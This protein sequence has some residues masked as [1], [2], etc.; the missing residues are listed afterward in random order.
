MDNRR[1]SASYSSRHRNSQGPL[2]DYQPSSSKNQQ[3]SGYFARAPRAEESPVIP[4]YAP[5][6]TA[7]Q[8]AAPSA[9]NGLSSGGSQRRRDSQEYASRAVRPV[10]LPSAPDAPRPVPSTSNRHQYPNENPGSHPPGSGLASYPARARAAKESMRN[11]AEEPY[12]ALSA[13]TPQSTDPVRRSSQTDKR[14][15][16][17]DRSP[18]QRLEVKLD[19][20]SKEEKRARLEE[21]EMLAEER[22]AAARAARANRAVSADARQS[23]RMSAMDADKKVPMRSNS[24]R[25]TSVPVTAS[26]AAPIDLSPPWDPSAKPIARSTSQRQPAPSS[27]PANQNRVGQSAVNRSVSLRD[28]DVPGRSRPESD[29][30]KPQNVNRNNGM[31]GLGLSGI[32]D[33]D[34]TLDPQKTANVGRQ[35]SR[36]VSIQPEEDT[37]GAGRNRG[38]SNIPAGKQQLH[39][40]MGR[41]FGIAAAQEHMQPDPLPRESVR[42]TREDVPKYEIPPQSAAGQL[43]RDQIGFSAKDPEITA[44]TNLEKS[45]GS[46]SL[47]LSDMLH[48][49]RDPVRRYQAPKLLDEWKR[50]ELASLFA[51]DLDLEAAVEGTDKDKAWWETSGSRRR[52]S[53]SS[54]NTAQHPRYDGAFEDSNGQT[55]FNPQL[56]LKCGPLLSYKGIRKAQTSSR[57]NV[58]MWRGTILIVTN[59]AQSSYTSRPVLRIFKQPMDILPP[60]PAR[61]DTSSGQQL[62]PEYVD[63]LAGQIKSS[64]T[65]KTLYARPVHEL[66]EEVDLSRVENDSGLFEEKK[67]APYG[68]DHNDMTEKPSTRLKAVDGEKLGK[69]KEVRGIRL[70]A[71]RRVTFWRFSVEIELGAEQARIAYRINR[72][73]AIG[74]WVPAKGETMNMMFYSCNGFSMGMNTN[75]FCGP[76]PLWRDVLNT[77]QTRP[78]HVMIGGGDQIYNDAA[79]R[80]TTLFR[81]WTTAK[82]PAHKHSEPFSPEMQDELEVFYLNRYSMWFSQG[83]YGMATSQIPMV[84]LWDDHDIIDVNASANKPYV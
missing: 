31:R 68:S 33:Q 75:Q 41:D 16:V 36:R 1:N 18:L 30:H 25:H 38:L 8:R 81:E 78:F 27:N 58:E 50:A 62:D 12:G 83:L 10:D 32:G 70:H 6:N 72:G 45:H 79:T 11:P 53:T 15:S 34:W 13:Q 52:R 9:N 23:R 84:N 22:A 26:D 7:R 61:L 67:S 49:H 77:H 19:D 56:Y 17:S 80:D 54:R 76:D 59:D 24:S 64:R 3:S 40:R 47:H 29:A 4:D 74:F 82:N 65:G 71:E 51:K 5:Q 28:R 57:R 21:A 46:H 60:P 20:I 35:D 48:R 39:D 2:P 44:S 43:A 63:P 69:F 42:N 66:D 14:G 55:V 73:P 37:G